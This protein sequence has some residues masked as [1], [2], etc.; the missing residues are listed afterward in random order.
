MEQVRLDSFEI[1]PTGPM[2]GKKMVEPKEECAGREEAVLAE[3]GL[4]PA[5]FSRQTGTR[6]PLRAPLSGCEVSADEAG[7]WLSFACPPGVY[8]TSVVREIAASGAKRV[9]R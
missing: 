5:L 8:A 2:N 1:S 9:A 6:R 4:E 7:V 3:L